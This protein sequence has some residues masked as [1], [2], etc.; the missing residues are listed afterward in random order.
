MYL[1]LLAYS[2]NETL[3][4]DVPEKLLKVVLLLLFFQQF[5]SIHA[6]ELVPKA[7]FIQDSLLVGEPV[8]FSVSLRYPKKLNL[9]LPDSTYDFSPFEIISRHY[10]PT[11]SDSLYSHD[12]VVYMLTSFYPDSLL[13]LSLPVFMIQGKDSL[14]LWTEP[15]QIR[16]GSVLV[17]T[18]SDTLQIESHTAYTAVEYPFNYPYFFLGLIGML[19]FIA[20]GV[21]VFGK[22]VRRKIRLWFLQRRFSSFDEAYTSKMSRFLTG[23]PSVRADELLL[24]WKN[25]LE[26]LEKKP[27]TKLT[28]QEIAEINPD[29]NHWLQVLRPIDRSIYGYQAGEDLQISLQQLQELARE[30]FD[31]RK[32]EVLNA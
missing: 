6:Q 10:F 1:S 8:A 24:L 19:V 27:Y 30:K 15:D 28:S 7:H 12:S 22:S 31:R 25:Y 18:A 9:L 20:S 2:R 11:R 17:G 32:Q 14:P 21:A 26:D 16:A 29:K 5:S 23:D 13:E 3:V 4:K